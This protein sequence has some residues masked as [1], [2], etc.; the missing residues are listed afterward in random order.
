MIQNF[1]R[2]VRFVFF[3]TLLLLFGVF[4]EL[5]TLLTLEAWHNV[6]IAK[7]KISKAKI[8][9]LSNDSIK[10]FEEKISEKKK[11]LEENFNSLSE[12]YLI[13]ISSKK[14]IQSIESEILEQ[15][16]LLIN[17]IKIDLDSFNE[18][19]NSA[20][21]IQANNTEYF[22]EKL[23][24]WRKLSTSENTTLRALRSSIEEIAVT[25]DNLEREIEL[26][27]IE[28]VNNSIS[29]SLEEAKELLDF[30]ERK[31]VFKNERE[32]L[33][34]YIT[35]AESYLKKEVE[36]YSIEEARNF[37][38]KSIPKLNSLK[39]KKNSL[40]EE[41]LR[42]RAEWIE[43]E[44][45]KR[46]RLNLKEAPPQPIDEDK[47]IFIILSEQTLYLYDRGE[48]ILSSPVTT[49]KN[50]T[51]TVTGDFRIY[52]KVYKTRLIANN[53]PDAVYNLAVDFWMPFYQGYG[54][55]DAYWRSVYG[56]PDY[57]WSG[58]HGCV[59]LPYNT[60]KFIWEWAEVGTPVI[61]RKTR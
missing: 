55:H 29:K 1:E 6:R 21:S 39:E 32:E 9:G 59:N 28:L 53:P 48:L 41:Y 26:K 2:K 50:K 54:L 52:A 44:K 60:A 43:N 3:S 22:L 5:H 33:K 8:E 30:F 37:V 45:S 17:L 40:D 19:L 13:S 16:T 58:S 10:Y 57:Q 31:Y 24:E 35:E 47:V 15:K 18:K 20:Y 56:G 4:Y 12:L 25:Y 14:I 46:E 51:P 34:K 7:E 11:N 42:K 38:E 49:G 23:L 61:I 36:Y 27:E